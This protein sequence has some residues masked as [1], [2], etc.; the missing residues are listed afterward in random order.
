MTTK[1]LREHKTNLSAHQSARECTGTDLWE[2]NQ[3]LHVQ[4]WYAVSV[5]CSLKSFVLN[6]LPYYSQLIYIHTPL[7]QSQV[8]VVTEAKTSRIQAAEISFLC[9][10]SWS[11]RWGAHLLYRESVEKSLLRQFGQLITVP[12][13][14]RKPLFLLPCVD[15]QCS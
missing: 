4:A 1:V 11:L 6:I 12:C 15:G 2:Q 3:I 9:W 7:L 14:G 10:D 8:W 13:L 5:L